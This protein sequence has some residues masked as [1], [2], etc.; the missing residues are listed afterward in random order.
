MLL[1][2]PR[3]G[4]R[5]AGLAAAVLG[6]ILAAYVVFLAVLPESA[7]T[8][9]FGPNADASSAVFVLLGVQALAAVLTVPANFVLKTRRRVRALLLG[10][11]LG[12]PGLVLGVVLV[13]SQGVVGLA[14]G[15]LV[16]TASTGVALWWTVVRD[17]GR[18]RSAARA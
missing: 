4:V 14:T 10:R 16:A 17:V 6:G 5:T 2:D 1:T 9:V 8:A 3:G 13:A 7:L 18:S 15:V 11:V 12:V